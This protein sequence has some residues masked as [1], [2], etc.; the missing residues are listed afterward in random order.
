MK[1][2]EEFLGMEF[3]NESTVKE[4]IAKVIDVLPDE[5]EKIRQNANIY[6]GDV[7]DLDCD[8]DS[9]IAKNK[10]T[11]SIQQFGSETVQRLRAKS[12][13][14]S[15]S[16]AKLASL[17]GDGD[18]VSQELDNLSREIKKL[19][20]SGVSYK[21]IPLLGIF[22]KS[23]RTYFDKYEKADDVIKSIVTSLERGQ[24][25]LNND[26]QTLIIEQNSSREIL[27]KLSKEIKMLEEMNKA[28]ND[29][30][31][32][33]ESANE[34]TEKITFIKEEVLFLVKIRLLDMRAMHAVSFQSIVSMEMI[35]RTNKQLSYSVDLAKTVT[36][37]VLRNAI[38]QLMAL[39]NQKKV[40]DSVDVL[41]NTTNEMFTASSRIMKEQTTEIFKDSTESVLGIDSLKTAYKDTFDALAEI[42]KFKQSALPKM[43]DNIT[44]LCELAEEGERALEKID[45]GNVVLQ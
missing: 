7:V 3:V 32:L 14:M 43:H 41:R 45:K 13:L 5:A 31:L 38:M 27:K 9:L 33:M 1:E 12:E 19:D 6:A 2:R 39:H 25:T 22:S 40:K 23:L 28:I 20:P 30:L 26:V 10:I 35:I 16:T 4:E 36:I 21:K 15:V 24:K 8:I 18:I 29:K 37:T 11:T 34:D 44:L 17:G 42:S